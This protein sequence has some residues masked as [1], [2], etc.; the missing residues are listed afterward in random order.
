MG[1]PLAWSTSM[2]TWLLAVDRYAF[3]SNSNVHVSPEFALPART[4]TS[5]VVDAAFTA[6]VNSANDES[7]SRGPHDELHDASSLPD[8]THCA[9]FPVRASYETCDWSSK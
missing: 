5:R 9:S 4:L 8:C 6:A 2:L 1:S 3:V 7:R